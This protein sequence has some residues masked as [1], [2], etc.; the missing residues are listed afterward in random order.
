MQ[1]IWESSQFREIYDV[2]T[3]PFEAKR[4]TLRVQTFCRSTS[5]W[6][7]KNRIDVPQPGIIAFLI[8]S[9]R[10]R[11]VRR[12]EPPQ[13]IGPGYFSLL[14]L[15]AV[16]ADFI[17]ESEKV[18]RLFILLEPNPLLRELLDLMFRGKLPSFHAG[19]PEKLR[20]CFEEIRRQIIRPDAD[21]ALIGGAA[22]AL[23]HEVLCQRPSVTLPEPLLRA[24]AYIG[25]RFCD[26][27][28]SRGDVARA[29]HV[30][31]STLAALFRLHLGKSVGDEIRDRRMAKVRQLLTFSNKPV[32]EIASECG[33]TYSY[34]LAREFR[35]AFG[36]TPLAFR[37]LTRN[38]PSQKPLHL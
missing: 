4:S 5:Y 2:N 17:A 31:V 36:S 33:F 23:L 37:R 24:R 18:E 22:Y 27:R 38:P 11:L 3:T 7:W 14:D 19:Q 35:K 29:A 32:S 30:S 16:D 25:R 13:E 28:L 1:H 6:N 34:Y 10:Q 9:G 8:L 26:P 20:Q 12:G 15:K 21:D